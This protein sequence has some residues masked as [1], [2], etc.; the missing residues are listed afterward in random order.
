MKESTRATEAHSSPC[1][2]VIIARTHPPGG[3]KLRDRCPGGP[4]G[5]MVG[6]TVQE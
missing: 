2:H 4:P 5:A 6:G 3:P 1:V